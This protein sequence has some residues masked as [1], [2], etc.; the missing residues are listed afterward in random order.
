MNLKTANIGSISHGT[1]RTEDLLHTFA[2][3]LEWQINRNGEFLSRP[4]NFPMCDRLAKLLGESQDAWKD[5]GETLQDDDIAAELVNELQDALNEFA[6]SHCSFSAHCGDG[7]DFGFWPMDME[8]IKEQVE[9]AS[10]TEQEYPDD[11]FSGE[12]LHINERGN[13][14]LYVRSNGKDSEIWSIV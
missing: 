3:E 5:D 14:T 4:E 6:P 7:S 10:S 2:S 1:L 9:F 11:D 12:W 8:E 13:C